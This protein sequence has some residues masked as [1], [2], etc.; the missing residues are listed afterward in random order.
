MQGIEIDM[1]LN[2]NPFI[3]LNLAY[4]YLDARDISENRVNDNLAYK[5]KHQFSISN[6]INIGYLSLLIDGRYR[7]KIE[8]V[9]IYPGSEPSANFLF[10][11]KMN[12]AISRSNSIFF[13]INNI[14]DVQYEELERYRMPGRNFTLGG[15]IQLR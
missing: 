6:K 14:T 4:H 1:R 7:S 2:I 8:E 15:K 13:A 12:M 9:F 5:I 3:N 11:V 10:N